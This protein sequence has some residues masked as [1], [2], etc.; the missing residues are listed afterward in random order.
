VR[1]ISVLTIR[2]LAKHSSSTL[3]KPYLIDLIVSLLETLSGYE[4]P[5][6]NYIALKLNSADAQ[7]KL[8][9]AR[10]AASKSTP[11]IEIIDMNLQHLNEEEIIA[12]LMPRLLEI[13]KRGLGVSTK[14]GVCHIICSLGLNFLCSVL[15]KISV[16][17]SK[18]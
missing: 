6:L 12:E 13:V 10:I 2:D 4:P 18:K 8:D 1:N 7:E 17:T 3:I 5:D 16:A 11:M 14:A 9:Q 15:Y